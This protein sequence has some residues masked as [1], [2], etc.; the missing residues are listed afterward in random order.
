MSRSIG[1]SQNSAIADEIIRSQRDSA[2]DQ[3]TDESIN[4]P[5]SL[6]LSSGHFQGISFVV[7]IV[8]VGRRPFLEIFSTCPKERARDVILRSVGQ[9]S[10]A[11]GQTTKTIYID[12]TAHFD[13]IVVNLRR[14]G[15][16]GRCEILTPSTFRHPSMPEV[17]L[18]GR[19]DFYIPYESDNWDTLSLLPRRLHRQWIAQAGETESERGR[20][21]ESKVRTRGNAVSY[22]LTEVPLAGRDSRRKFAGKISLDVAL[23]RTAAPHSS[24]SPPPMIFTDA[25]GE[26]GRGGGGKERAKSKH[27]R[28]CFVGTTTGDFPCSAWHIAYFKFEL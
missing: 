16:R 13:G 2:L 19:S 6:P 27:Q 8:V 20:E 21:S 9:I 22:L 1:W 14:S 11:R 23:P 4:P 3:F 10:A 12:R 15:R 5:L 7:V 24:A 26:G 18:D 17:A 25:A 28:E